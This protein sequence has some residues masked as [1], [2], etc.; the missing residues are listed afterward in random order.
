MTPRF[1]NQ[2]LSSSFPCKVIVKIFFSFKYAA[3][4]SCHP[5]RL[6]TAMLTV[7]DYK[8]LSFSLCASIKHFKTIFP[9]FNN[10]HFSNLFPQKFHFIN[11]S[12]RETKLRDT[13]GCAF[14]ASLRDT[15]GCAFSASLRDIRE[16]QNAHP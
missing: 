1:Y 4:P 15:H 10:I 13:H 8:L 7:E 12:M 14:C 16:A 2:P 11:I 5:P 6:K 3:C 9:F